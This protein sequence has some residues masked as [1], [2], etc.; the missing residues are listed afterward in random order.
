ML[1]PYYQDD[2]VT[3]YQGDSR[4]IL[5]QL[6][7]ASFDLV[8]ADP[9]Y[10][11]T[12]LAWDQRVAGWQALVRPLLKPSGSLWCF[13]SL[14]FFMAEGMAAGFAGWRL[15]QDLVWEKHNG[16]NFHSDRFKRVHENIAQ[17]YPAGMRWTDV[18]KHPVY[19]LDATRRTIRRKQR[20]SHLGGIGAGHYI[21]E[22]GGPRLM[23]SVIYARSC[24]GY[25]IHKTQKPIPCLNPVLLYSCPPGGVVLDPFAGAGSTLVAAADQG[26][27]AVGIEIREE[28]C[29][30]AVE[31][32]QLPLFRRHAA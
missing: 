19:T 27:R 8:L 26:L 6:P 12:S 14:R 29:E 9:P 3:L 17:F 32:L 2:H 1:K 22:D 23:R 28:A 20:P 15:A 30:Q 21:A 24:H 16:S 11:E 5:P 13:G 4:E 31:R 25:A 10:G 18:Y 7:Q